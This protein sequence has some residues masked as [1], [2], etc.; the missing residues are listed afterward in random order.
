MV[1]VIT[2]GIATEE[3]R[4]DG[5]YG[6]ADREVA[7][8]ESACEAVDSEARDESNPAGGADAAGGIA[9]TLTADTVVSSQGLRTRGVDS[10]WFKS[11]AFCDAHAP[12]GRSF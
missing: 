3:P 8:G 12:L 5:S 7:V 2:S 4:R 10:C 11:T 1:T 6:G 9:D